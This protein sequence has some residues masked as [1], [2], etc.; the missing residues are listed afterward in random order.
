MDNFRNFS[1]GSA[2]GLF[3]TIINLVL[4]LIANTISKKI[5]EGEVSLF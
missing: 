5:S 2:V 4:V 3:N 1:Y